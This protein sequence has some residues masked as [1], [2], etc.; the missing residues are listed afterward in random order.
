MEQ[1]FSFLSFSPGP[2]WLLILFL[3][4]N[5][6]AQLAIDGFLFLLTVIYS[7][8]ILPEVN[9]LLPIIAQPTLDAIQRIF[10]APRGTVGAWNHMILADLWIGRWI[11]R[12]SVSEKHSFFIRLVFIP[13]TLFFGPLGLLAYWL[14]RC[15]SRRQFSLAP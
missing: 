12:D 2:F 13:I 8:I 4:S 7:A 11:A 1:L 5:A 3:P 9:A 15:V 10:S 6:K 14:Y